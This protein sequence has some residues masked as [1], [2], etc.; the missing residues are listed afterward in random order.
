MTDKVYAFNEEGMRALSREVQALR[1]QLG[2]GRRLATYGMRRHQPIWLPGS[3]DV[4]IV[5]AKQTIY[6]AWGGGGSDDGNFISYGSAESNALAISL[7]NYVPLS[8]GSLA[9]QRRRVV[10][11]RLCYV[12]ELNSDN[13]LEQTDTEI[14]V[15]NF[16]GLPI[17]TNSQFAVQKLAGSEY[18]IPIAKP[19]ELCHAGK[20]F[21]SQSG[22]T[23]DGDGT[24]KL[25]RADWELDV[26]PTLS[27][28][29]LTTD[30]AH[31]EEYD[32]F[33]HH[34][35]VYKV[36]FG[37]MVSRTSSDT[38]DDTEYTDSNSDTVDIPNT[39]NFSA[40]LVTNF[41]PAGGTISTQFNNYFRLGISV[42]PKDHQLVSTERTVM[43]KHTLDNWH[44]QP[45]MRLSFAAKCFGGGADAA[46]AAGNLGQ[47]WMH[48]EPMGGG[49]THEGSGFNAFNG[50]TYQWYGQG[51]VPDELFDDDG[52]EIP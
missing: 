46:S 35:G 1:N 24:P 21:L 30:F 45:Y 43:I 5:N 25:V 49:G 13:V 23:L 44:G 40:A 20:I 38:A 31:T 14:S 29:N 8:S 51:T 10:Y 3:S 9:T 22:I 42:G 41:N 48:I 28:A 36:T 27:G 15:V 33:I 2:S 32:V 11:P 26:D 12:W 50:S 37:M 17:I 52:V 34:P 47:C 39:M 4:K 18:Y 6:A 16:G 19:S 7:G